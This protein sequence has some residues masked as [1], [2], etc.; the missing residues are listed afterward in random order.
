MIDARPTWDQY[1]M[2][3]AQ[4]A[5]TKSRDPSTKV[6]CVMV[7]PDRDIRATGFNGL[8]RGVEDHPD[9]MERPAKYIWTCH[10]EENAIAHAAR[11]GTSM[12]G[13]TAYVTHS[14]C[15]RCARSMIQ[16]GIDKVVVGQGHLIAASY[17]EEWDIARAMFKEAGV[18]VHHLE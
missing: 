11:A 12:L 2:G 15:A 8:P 5:A 10:A 14:T 13:C 3:F 9:R 17:I 16:A 4:H 7:G 6:G 1:F 18:L